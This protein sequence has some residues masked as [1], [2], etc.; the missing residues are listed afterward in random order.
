M[1]P[2]GR[3]C[4]A[5]T[6]ASAHRFQRQVHVREPSGRHLDPHRALLAAGDEDAR[7]PRQL[8]QFRRQHAVGKV[9]DF[10]GGDDLGGQRQRDHGEAG[11]VGFPV[12]RWQEPFRQI[13]A[14]GVDRG[15]HRAGRGVEIHRQIELGDDVG[16][17]GA[18]ER[19]HL[20]DAGDQA[21]GALERLRQR[22]CHGVRAGARQRRI[23]LDGRSLDR[24]QGCDRQPQIGDAGRAA[25][26]RSSAARSQPAEG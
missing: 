23:D 22:G 8:R 25:A 20:D 21:D 15:L 3:F 17:A 9:V 2:F 10:A 24:R 12:E 13:A 11:R 19:G 16:A 26:R 1:A 4:D 18:A 6:I 5:A 7:H 14:G